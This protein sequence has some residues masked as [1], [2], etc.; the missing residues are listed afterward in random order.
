[1]TKRGCRLAAW[2]WLLFG[3]GGGVAAA[4]PPDVPPE[5]QPWREWVLDQEDFRRCPFLANSDAQARNAYVCAWPERLSLEVAATSARFSQRWIVYADS[6]I[7]LPGNEEHWP[8]DVTVNGAAAA[9]V[10]TAGMATPRLRLTAGTYLVSGSFRW[11]RRPEA[12]PVPDQV[13]LVDLTVDGQAIVQPERPAGAVW[14]GKR[15]T[16]QQQEQMEIQVYRR[17][18]DWIP[19]RLTTLLRLQI[20]GDGREELLSRVLPEGYVPLSLEGNLPARIEPDGRLRVQARAGSWGITIVARGPGVAQSLRRPAPNGPWARDEIW[21]FAA[22]DR[23]RVVAVEGVSGV[24]PAQT[25]VPPQWAELPAYA[26]TAASEMRIVE[27]SRGLAASDDNELRLHRTL[28]LDFDHDGYTIVDAIAGKMREDWRLEVAAPQRLQS[29]TSH[30]ENLLVTHGTTE[31]LTGIELREPNVSVRAVSR[32]EKG[33]A[34][35]A[36]G[37]QGRFANVQGLLHVPPGHRLLTAIGADDASWAWIERW[38]LLDLFLVLI[39]TAAV[40]RLFGWPAGVLALV[41]LGLTH[42]DNEG[43]MVWLWINLLIAFVLAREAPEG[44]LRRVAL[45]YRNVSALVLL[46]VLIPFAFTQIRLALYPQLAFVGGA[47]R[48]S[49]RKHRPRRP[50]RWRRRHHPRRRQRRNSTLERWRRTR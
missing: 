33:S 18:D 6:W 34:L 43:Q 13:G 38:R 25:G 42:H 49:S 8:R 26:M 3:G 7:P 31:G 37:W 24:D 14:L 28:W 15:R 44:R 11:A 30:G 46:I 17:V 12:L 36:T 20:A 50:I 5:L 2:A 22:D 23:L 19:V 47:S 9:V 48:G 45:G 4:A 27:R 32:V 41:A 21:S 16:A 10:S 39:A 40:A 29:A 35:S 1:M